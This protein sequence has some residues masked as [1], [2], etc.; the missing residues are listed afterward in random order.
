MVRHAAVRELP[1]AR[2]AHRDVPV[3]RSGVGQR[4]GSLSRDSRG[5][6]SRMNRRTGL[7]VAVFVAGLIGGWLLTRAGLGDPGPV[8]APA[9]PAPPTP[10]GQNGLSDAERA[11]L[12][13]L[14]EGGELFPVDW[15]LALEVESLAS[16]G[17]LQVRPFLDNIERYGLLPDPRSVGNPDGLPVGVSLGRSKAED[18]DML[19][20]NCSDCHVG[21]V[22]Y[23][24]RAVRID[25]LG[26]MALINAFLTDLATETEKTL[27]SPR[28]LVRFWKRVRAVREAR[29]AQ[30]RQAD[31]TAAD[32]TALGRIRGLLTSN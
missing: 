7:I 10:E 28:R 13:H 22:Q 25:G 23:Q 21:Q 6:G 24:G 4:R 17:T 32:E 29:R 3:R 31:G 30:G 15:L 14:S 16:D 11:S 20:L 8:P 1:D 5:S 26:N 19:G 12:Y 27:V 18:I 9:L 2:A